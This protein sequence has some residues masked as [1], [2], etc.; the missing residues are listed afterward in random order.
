MTHIR[1][2]RG[3]QFI[4]FLYLD[5][6]DLLFP[7]LGYVGG[8]AYD[9][10]RRSVIVEFIGAYIG[11]EPECFAIEDTPVSRY[12]VIDLPLQE[13]FELFIIYPVKIIRMD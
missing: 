2:E 12:E 11:V 1:Q 7:L 10:V 5:W 9:P 13:R 3:L 6:L 8:V 4:S